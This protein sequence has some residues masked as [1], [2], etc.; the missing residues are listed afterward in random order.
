MPA[1]SSTVRLSKLL[2]LMLRHRPQEFDLEVDTQGFAQLDAVVAALKKKDDEIGV[3]EVESIVDDPEK[4]RFEIVDGKIRARYGHSFRVDLGLN[5]AEPPEALYKGVS[6]RDL[7]DTLSTGLKPFDRQYVHLSYD[8]D[9]A[10]RLGRGGNAVVRIDAL[11]AHEAGVAF[12][13]CGPTMLTELIPP[14]F[15]TLDREAPDRPPEPDRRRPS[16]IPPQGAPAAPQPAAAPQPVAETET[17]KYGR[18]RQFRK[19]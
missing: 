11:S 2:S 6:P 7:D 14:E 17:P 4:K 8:A 18:R 19:R 15:L 3:A 5:A 13:D 10:A 1:P 16:H 12:F 9:V